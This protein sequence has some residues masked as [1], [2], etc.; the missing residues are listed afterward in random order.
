MTKRINEITFP[1][2]PSTA[3]CGTLKSVMRPNSE[4]CVTWPHWPP[5]FCRN[6]PAAS[7][8]RPSASNKVYFQPSVSM[9]PC[10]TF[11]VCSCNWPNGDFFIYGWVVPVASRLQICHPTVGNKMQNQHGLLSA[12]AGGAWTLAIQI[13]LEPQLNLSDPLG[14]HVFAPTD[15]RRPRG[16][17]THVD[18]KTATGDL[19]SQRHMHLAKLS[20]AK[21]WLVSSLYSFYPP[22]SNS[23]KI[24]TVWP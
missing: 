20:E 24:N 4:R 15:K 14:A 21:N 13:F 22:L 8:C 1:H 3:E 23:P 16:S 12:S 2:F 18:R 17:R 9:H 19:N 6:S 7:K 11:I 10:F 5:P